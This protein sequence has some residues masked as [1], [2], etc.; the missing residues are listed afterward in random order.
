MPEPVLAVIVVTH[1]SDKWLPDFFESWEKGIERTQIPHEVIVADADSAVLPANVPAGAQVL[2]CGNVGYGASINRAVAASSAPWLLLCNPDLYF[3]EDFARDFLKRTL[4]AP[5]KGA[6]CIAPALVNEDDTGQPSVGAFPT[7]RRLIT[8]QFR[9][10]MHRKFIYPHAPGFC[11]WATG[12]CLLIQREH[13]ERVGG[14]DEKFFLYVEEVDLQKRLAGV[15]LRT[16]AQAESVMHMAPNAAAPR[17]SAARHSARGML[18]YFAKH[19]SA[20]QLAGYRWLALLSGRLPWGEAF[21][22]KG[23]ILETATGP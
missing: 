9:A 4:E 15:G 6:G 7:I 16:F 20:G 18:R 11:D 3:H 21:A 12:A 5:P 13:F 23:K 19:G 8:D 1:N 17:K 2:A 14:F 22:S 10:P